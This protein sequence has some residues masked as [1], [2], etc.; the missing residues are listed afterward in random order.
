MLCLLREYAPESQTTDEIYAAALLHDVVEDTPVT[1]QE[2]RSEFGD[3]VADYVRG[4][5]K[6][7]LPEH[8]RAKRKFL[9]AERLADCPS[10]VQTIKCAD[11]LSNMSSIVEHDRKFAKLFMA[12][13][14]VLHDKMDFAGLAIR[15]LLNSELLKWEND[16]WR[17][18]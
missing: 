13:T 6:L 12:E 15:E 18:E 16:S 2:I 5:T 17:Y 4:M 10:A 7:E 9:E 3:V 1:E 11:L 14:R 8:N